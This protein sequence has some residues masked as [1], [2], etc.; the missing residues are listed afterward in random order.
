MWVWRP[1]RTSKMLLGQDYYNLCVVVLLHTL[2]ADLM[3][4]YFPAML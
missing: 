1:Q 4:T 3:Y 2:Y